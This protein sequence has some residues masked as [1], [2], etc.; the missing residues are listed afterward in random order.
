MQRTADFHD[1][2]ADAC[3]SQAAGVVDDATA[4]DTAVDVLD[5][6]A[7]AG[8]A[9]I[10]GFLG[11]R[12]GPAPRLFGRHDHLDRRERKRQKAQILEQPAACGQRVR[13]GLG[14]PLIVDT[15]RRGFTQK[16]D[17]QRGV[18]QQ[19]V[20][21]CV[22]LFL[23]TITARLRSRILGARDTPFGALV[24]KRGEAGADAGVAAG[25]SAGISG[26]GVGTTI[27][28]ASAS[29]T[30]RRCANAC[31]DRLGASPSARTAARRTT[32]RT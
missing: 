28:L 27:A 3:L 14:N 20:F 24:P 1:Q 5:A 2:I 21:D 7:P 19:H 22:A 23:A 30:P 25:G 29:A 8:K 16:E 18:D 11:A 10:R 6:H 32:K 17:R 31:T 12:E 9:P 15:A 13:G 4:L 26:A